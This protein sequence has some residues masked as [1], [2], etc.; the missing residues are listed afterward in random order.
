MKTIKELRHIEAENLA[1]RNNPNPTQEE[2]ANALHIMRVFYKFVFAYQA[3][4][5]AEQDRNTTQAEQAA[6]DAKSKRA[7]K[8]AAAALKPYK[9]KIAFPG[10]Y[11]IIEE[12]SGEHFTMGFYY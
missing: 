4:F 10:L 8:R 1:K 6:A 2:I 3:A 11:P 9:L 5:Y 7:Y 12:E